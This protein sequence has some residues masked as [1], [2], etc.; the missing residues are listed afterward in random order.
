MNP[1]IDECP[2]CLSCPI[3]SMYL[4]R[5][6]TSTSME[7]RPGSWL[8]W[9]KGRGWSCHAGAR[10]NSLNLWQ[11][12]EKSTQFLINGKCALRSSRSLHGRHGFVTKHTWNGQNSNQSLTR[13]QPFIQYWINQ[14]NL[15]IIPKS[16]T[17]QN[18][19]QSKRKQK[20]NYSQMAA[21]YC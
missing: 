19:T 18:S 13:S 3:R 2:I 7:T 5:W 8:S 1:F 17:K 9:G 10:E 11:V 6:S 16:T 14:L 21:I 15:E 20:I 4:R 12:S